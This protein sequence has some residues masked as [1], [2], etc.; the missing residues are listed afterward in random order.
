MH[1][2]VYNY[3][4]IIFNVDVVI[5]YNRNCCCIE[6]GKLW[7]ILKF[8]LKYILEIILYRD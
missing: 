6:G 7:A 8:K 5:S 4:N 3:Y 1:I 2:N